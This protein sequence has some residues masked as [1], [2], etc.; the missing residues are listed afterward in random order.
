MT[1]QIAVNER[2]CA[3]AIGM[4]VPWLRKDRRTKRLIPFFRIGTAVRYN[5]DRV[6]EALATMEEG[7]QASTTSRSR[8]AVGVATA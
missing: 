5:I 3:Q 2:A 4:S 8:R 1:N 6:R 7:G